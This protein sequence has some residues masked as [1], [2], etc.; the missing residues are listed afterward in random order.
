M[1]VVARSEP[2]YDD[3]PWQFAGTRTEIFESKRLPLIF[4]SGPSKTTCF[5]SRGGTTAR[6]TPTHEGTSGMTRTFPSSR[7]IKKTFSRTS[8]LSML[9]AELCPLLCGHTQKK[10]AAYQ[11]AV[12]LT[13]TRQNVALSSRLTVIRLIASNSSPPLPQRYSSRISSFQE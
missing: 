13:R 8:D 6:K 10:C 7:V 1:P 2:T 11:S 4:R 5:P 3:L 12:G 9:A